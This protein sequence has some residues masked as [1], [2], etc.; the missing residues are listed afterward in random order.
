[1]YSSFT[2]LSGSPAVQPCIEGSSW[3]PDPSTGP[4]DC[5]LRF[6]HKLVCS[7]AADAQHICDLL[8][9]VH[10]LFSDLTKLT[11]A[12]SFSFLRSR[13]ADSAQHNAENSTAAAGYYWVRAL[14]LLWTTLRRPSSGSGISGELYMDTSKRMKKAATIHQNAYFKK[15]FVFLR[16][17]LGRRLL[18]TIAL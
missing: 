3:H 2:R 4:D 9:R 11:V 6:L 16:M 8:H 14:N 10:T 5:E 13:T 18:C 17:S 12:H 1:M 7:G 15:M